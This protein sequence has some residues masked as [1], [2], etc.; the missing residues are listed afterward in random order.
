[1]FK[2]IILGVL[3][4]IIAFCAWNCNVILYGINQGIG[5]V[6]IVR[7]AKPIEEVLKDPNFPDSLKS[8]L[9]LIQEIKKFAVDSLGICKSDNYTTVYDQKGEP[10]MWVIT[11]CKPY[12]FE[13]YEWHFPFLGKFTYKG[14][15]KKEKAEKELAEL[16]AEGYD[17]EL[18]TAKAYST[19]G[20]FKDPIL[21]EMLKSHPGSIARLIIHELTHGTLYIKDSVAYNENL[22]TFVGDKGAILFLKYKYGEQSKEMKDYLGNITDIKKFSK[23]VLSGM[24]ESDQLYK[25]ERFINLPEEQKKKEKTEKIKQITLAADTISFY[26]KERFSELFS[27]GFEANNNFFLTYVMYRE[28][29]SLFEVEF[30][31]KFHSNF[32]EYL[33]YLKSKYST[34]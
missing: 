16:K 1:M 11:A 7:E 27:P 13:P 30:R 12:S 26:N 31:T 4:L 5:Q 20:I 19:L 24:K 9:L 6:K 29:Q 14:Y 34:L 8:K 25:S 21:S 10:I 2:K 18:G 3:L 15:F 33:N 22:A 28:D 23:H 17:I 32:K